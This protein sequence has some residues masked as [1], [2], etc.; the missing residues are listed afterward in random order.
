LIRLATVT[1]IPRGSG[2]G[3][4][5]GSLHVALF[6]TEEGFFATGNICSHEHEPMADGWL[7]GHTV[8][9]PRHGAQFDL[10]TGEA[11]TLPAIDPIEVFSLEIKGDE[12]WAAI[13]SDYLNPPG[14]EQST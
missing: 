2:K 7:E 6:H 8:E 4:R 12:I 14:N 1:Q 5:V 10:R 9:C 13:P 11:L 3:F